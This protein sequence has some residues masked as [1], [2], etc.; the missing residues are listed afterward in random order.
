MSWKPRETP[1]EPKIFINLDLVRTSSPTFR[2]L[3]AQLCPTAILPLLLCRAPPQSS[4]VLLLC[5][6]RSTI[7]RPSSSTV[8]LPQTPGGHV[9]AYPGLARRL[10]KA[11]MVVALRGRVAAAPLVLLFFLTFPYRHILFPSSLPAF[12]SPTYSC[13]GPAAD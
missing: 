11:L 13:H 7:R 10:R 9:A 1:F 4:H 2:L 6:R 3:P 12:L 5:R 8:A